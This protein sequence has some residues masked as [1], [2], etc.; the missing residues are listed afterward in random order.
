MSIK[1]TIIVSFAI[2]FSWPGMLQAS[3]SD[4]EN[5]LQNHIHSRL[6]CLDCHFYIKEN[7]DHPV[8]DN[9]NTSCIE[10]H[11]NFIEFRQS[12]KDMVNCLYCHSLHH[13]KIA[14][15]AHY[16]VSCKACHFSDFI[17]FKSTKNNLTKWKYETAPTG[18]FDPH[19][20]ITG[21]EEMCSRCHFKGNNLGASDHALPVKSIICMPCH[22]ATFSFGDIFSMTAIVIFFIGILNILIVWFASGK[23]HTKYG[24]NKSTDLTGI[25]EALIFDGF[26]QRRLLKVSFKR[27]G[28]H[29]I[30]F[31]PLI[32]RFI[33]GLFALVL[34]ITIPEWDLTRKILD[35]NNPFTGFIFDITGLL[36]LTGG[37][38][39]LLNKWADRKKCI[40]KGF[41]KSNYSIQILL[42]GIIITGFLVEGA[43]IAMTGVPYGSQYA[44]I[45]FLISKA[46]MHSRL[47]EIYAYIWYIHSI[48][49]AVFIVCLPFSRMFHVFL[50]P[51]SLGLMAASRE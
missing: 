10:C 47:N 1:F 40:I 8:V 23:G 20:M 46:L 22:A 6:L 45:G 35:K 31:F 27:W 38:F 26:F 41:P 3:Q 14:H 51:L 5:K 30:I 9:S 4:G 32:V 16:D 15:D 12:R 17:P 39:M 42:S 29:A 21:K 11:E 13:E 25:F 18:E 37:C 7:P 34:S 2:L 49:T 43:R 24:K 33:W 28:I 48:A 50:T 19:R 36:I 44:F